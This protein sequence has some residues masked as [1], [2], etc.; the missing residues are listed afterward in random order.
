MRWTLVINEVSA[1]CYECE[2][3]RSDHRSVAKRGFESAIPEVLRDAFEMEL[4]LGTPPYEAAFYIIEGLKP[5][6]RTRFD[7]DGHQSWTVSSFIEPRGV[8][9]NAETGILRVFKNSQNSI[10]TGVV[11]DLNNQADG[12]FEA[13]SRI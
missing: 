8:E 13:A 2:A 4:S 9:Y 11:G 1:G 5:Q 3:I 12:L 6:W 10:W 7:F